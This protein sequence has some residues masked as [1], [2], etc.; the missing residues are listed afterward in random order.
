MQG[1][2]LESLVIAHEVMPG[3]RLSGRSPPAGTACG[4]HQSSESRVTA[5][6]AKNRFGRLC[7]QAKRIPV[8]VDKAG[9]IDTVIVVAEHDQALQAGEDKA[10][11]VARTQPS[12]APL[13]VVVPGL[14]ALRDPELEGRAKSPTTS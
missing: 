2:R 6:E 13:R 10:G 4:R 5:T 11:R 12:L 8:F 9:Q 14:K 1:P 7:T 3:D